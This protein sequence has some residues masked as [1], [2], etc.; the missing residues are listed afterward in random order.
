M[1]T[2][3][4]SILF[5]FLLPFSFSNAKPSV[6][7]SKT[8][9]QILLKLIE[10]EAPDFDA[11]ENMVLEQLPV[12]QYHTDATGA[13]FHHIRSSF[14][15]ALAL[16]NS[17]ERSYRNRAFDVIRKTLN[18][19][20]QDPKSPTCGVWPYYLEEPFKTKK[21]PPD[22]NMADFNAVTLIE[23]WMNH[24]EIL[25]SDIKINLRKGLSLAAYSIK[26]RAISNGYTNIA[27]MG[28]Y[29]TYMAA[30]IS[31]DKDLFLYAKNRLKSFYD[32][33][34]QKGGFTE[35]NTPHY[36][37][38]ALDELNRMQLFIADKNDKKMVDSLYFMGWDM[39]AR[40]YHAPTGQSV[41]P[42]SRVYVSLVP[43]VYTNFLSEALGAKIIAPID[44]LYNFR[45]FG[46][47]R[48]KVP[49]TLRHYF[50]EPVFPRT[51][52]DVFEPD[53][54]Q[55]IG[56]A[57]MTSKFA[58]SSCNQA[59]L[60]NQRRPLIA[61][62]GTKPEPKYLQVRFL[63]DNYDFSSASITTQ[64]KENKV[65]A[66]VNFSKGLGD[67]HINI[68]MIKNGKFK[69]SDLRLRFEFGSASLPSDLPLPTKLNQP[70]SFKI[71]GLWFSINI[72]EAGFENNLGYWEK[73]AD[74][75]SSWI[76]FVLYKGENNEFDLNNLQKAI[77]AFTLSMS[78][79]QSDNVPIPSF[80]Y[81]GTLLNATW[82]DL[83]ISISSDVRKVKKHGGWF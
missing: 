53:T 33:S 78:D 19:Q 71:D 32:Y 60:W 36:T 70:M 31:E 66:G 49:A 24:A 29:V 56:T 48:H 42:N 21:S 67:K 81:D 12:Y 10:K 47:T 17:G 26:K 77:A 41:G 44:S 2:Q 38:V 82:G 18:L 20:D 46:R 68:D 65:L 15:Y 80:I 28:T 16:L 13:K 74:A 75:N 39:L 1:K 40:H 55:T 27:V 5:F 3:F 69:V 7:L 35:Y 79:K 14:Q 25:P 43:G 30:Q 64:Q 45:T 62:W 4:L 22:Y 83:K 58:L 34:V 23:I 61:Y 76:D 72:F 9:K 59:V 63:H 52:I 54:P 8:Q 37:A 6:D 73:G 50:T 57:Y 51:E 11:K